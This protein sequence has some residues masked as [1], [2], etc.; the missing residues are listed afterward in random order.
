MNEIG[1]EDNGSNNGGNNGNNGGGGGN[2]GKSKAKEEAYHHIHRHQ[3]NY[4]DFQMQKRL[5]RKEDVLDGDYHRDDIIEWDGQ[6][7]DWRDIILEESIK[8][9]GLLTV[10]E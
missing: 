6:H 5:N 4:Q 3:K 10:N 9:S 2:K 8:E 7:G 1:R